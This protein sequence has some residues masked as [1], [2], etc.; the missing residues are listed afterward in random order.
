MKTS[1]DKQHK[2]VFQRACIELNFACE[3]HETEREGI[4]NVYIRDNKLGEVQ[5]QVAL[6]LGI[7]IGSMLHVELV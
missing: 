1:I 6:W 2:E 7:R 5:P 3:F 4:L